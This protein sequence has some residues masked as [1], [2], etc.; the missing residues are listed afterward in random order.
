MVHRRWERLGG[1]TTCEQHSPILSSLFFERSIY[2]IDQSLVNVCICFSM[3]LF[4]S[5]FVS[6]VDAACV[7]SG[8]CNDEERRL[9][10]ITFPPALR[11]SCVFAFVRWCIDGGSWGEVG[12]WKAWWKRGNVVGVLRLDMNEEGSPSSGFSAASGMSGPLLPLGAMGIRGVASSPG[13]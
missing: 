11:H 1:L 13:G 12:H 4:S 5:I 2:T 8:W 10:G 3:C 7:C 9:T 6:A